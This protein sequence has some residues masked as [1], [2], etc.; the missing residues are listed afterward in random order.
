M[1]RQRKLPSVKNASKQYLRSAN[2]LGSQFDRFLRKNCHKPPKSLV[3]TGLPRSGTTLVYEIVVQAFKVAYFSKIYSY[4]YG[5]PNLTTRLVSAF[6][7]NPRAHYRSKYGSLPGFFSPAENH[8]FWMKW[9]P[10]QPFLGHHVPFSALSAKDVTEINSTLASISCIAGRPYV[11]KDV[12]LSLS[13]DSLLKSVDG[14]RV[15]LVTRDHDAVAA[16]VYKRRSE[17]SHETPWW[18]IRPP[19]SEDVFEKDLIKQVAFQCTRSEQLIQQQLS[20]ADPDRYRIV[21]YA[22]VCKS[23]PAFVEQMQTWLGTAFEPRNQPDVPDHFETRASQG[24]PDEIG[25]QY[26]DIYTSLCNDKERYLNRIRTEVLKLHP[27][28]AM[29]A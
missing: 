27:V 12:Y 15:L 2:N 13:L 28:S 14:A 8:N 18:S 19:F 29:P 3:V 23:P 11:F 17:I 6:M 26:A 7:K 1:S 9:F 21:K 10:E 16:S 4:A 22:D 20:A 25:Q 24:F 5:M